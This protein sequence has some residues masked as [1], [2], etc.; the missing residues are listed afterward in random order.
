MAEK[1]FFSSDNNATITI[2]TVLILLQF[3]VFSVFCDLHGFSP[4]KMSPDEQKDVG[5]GGGGGGGSRSGEWFY[6]SITKGFKLPDRDGGGGGGGGVGKFSKTGEILTREIKIKQ[7]KLRG[8]VK[9]FKNK[10]LKNVETFLG[11]PYAAPPVKSL[12]FMPPGSP[13]T[14]KDVKIFDYFKPVCPQ[15]APD[16]N[17]EPLKTIN[18]GYYNRLKRL[19]PFLTNQSEDC[20]Y[21]NVYAPVRGKMKK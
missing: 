1:R 7:G 20:L 21:L 9:E 15:K 18:A 13:P 12:R 11:I 14:W 4:Q 19:M 16:L 10:K 2:L 8:L 3:H 17:H 5:S 6:K